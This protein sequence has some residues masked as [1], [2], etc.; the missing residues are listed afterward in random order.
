[1]VVQPTWYDKPKP[2]KFQVDERDIKRSPLGNEISVGFHLSGM[3]YSVIIP[4]YAWDPNEST[5]PGV[6]VGESNGMVLVSF[7]ATS[8]GAYTLRI[9][10]T[11]VGEISC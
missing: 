6:Q 3:G 9:P 11:V 2:I 5:I 4:A 10:K 1:M 7:P 8:L